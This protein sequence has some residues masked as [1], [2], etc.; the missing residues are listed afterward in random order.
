LSIWEAAF[1]QPNCSFQRI[2]SD[3][4]AP[5]HLVTESGD[6]LAETESQLTEDLDHIES[7]RGGLAPGT[8]RVVGATT[9]VDRR[10]D[11]KIQAVTLLPVLQGV[12][13]GAR[14]GESNDDQ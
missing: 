7:T 1:R 14:N 3:D 11:G 8:L 6:Q 12:V 13:R 4:G 9:V 10:S 2:A 5:W